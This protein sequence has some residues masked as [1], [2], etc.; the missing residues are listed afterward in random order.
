MKGRRP[1][2]THAAD[3]GEKTPY[4]TDRPP[5]ELAG[6]VARA[7]WEKTIRDLE[8]ENRKLPRSNES[9]LIGLCS[10]CQLLADAERSLAEHGL[11]VDAGR[12][13]SRRNPAL[14]AKTSALT[15]IRGFASEIGLTPASAGRL[16]LPPIED[17]P[18]DFDEF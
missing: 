8:A 14:S 11:I 4:L 3:H 10:A 18:G 13:G 16:P 6:E 9:A 15:S 7:R 17:E 5:A 1:K 2:A 12:E